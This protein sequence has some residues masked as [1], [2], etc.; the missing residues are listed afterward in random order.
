MN[1]KLS[2]PFQLYIGC[3]P[4]EAREGVICDYL[5]KFDPAISATLVFKKNQRDCRGYGTLTCSSQDAMVRILGAEHHLFDRRIIIERVKSQEEVNK[6]YKDL[7]QRKLRIM[8]P[9]SLHHNFLW[10]NENFIA[11]FG[12]FG[13]IENAK[14]YPTPEKIHGEY[15]YVGNLTFLDSKNARLLKE[16]N[17]SSKHGYIIKNT[18]SPK[19]KH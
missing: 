16:S 4:K 7:T 3:L 11:H 2:N 17:D 12:T 13:E 6:K 19:Q 15:Y 8:F 18:I 14:L 1:S 5:S 9:I 10:T